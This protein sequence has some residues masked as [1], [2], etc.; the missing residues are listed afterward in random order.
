MGAVVFR[1]PRQNLEIRAGQRFRRVLA[2]R[3]VETAQVLSVGKDATGIP[4][5]RFNVVRSRPSCIDYKEGPRVLALDSFWTNY[6]EA[7]EA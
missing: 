4:H 7:V 3:A 6:S 2:D 1:K 5:V